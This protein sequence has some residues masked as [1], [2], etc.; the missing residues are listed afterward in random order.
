M[1]LLFEL[2]VDVSGKAKS[3]ADDNFG[4]I[5]DLVHLESAALSKSRRLDCVL[6]SKS[7]L[8]LPS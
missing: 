1:C 7:S 2:A 6:Q 4:A 3:W 8:W 5:L